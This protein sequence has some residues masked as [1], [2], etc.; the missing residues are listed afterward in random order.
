[1]M[2]VTPSDAVLAFRDK[3]RRTLRNG[4]IDKFK[5]IQAKISQKFKD[6]ELP[7]G[8]DDSNIR[9]ESD[10]VPTFNQFLLSVKKDMETYWYGIIR[11]ILHTCF[12]DMLS[13][14]D[15]YF[16]I[17]YPSLHLST[18]IRQNFDNVPTVC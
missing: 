10:N 11:I 7:E 1:M 5:E 3:M 18:H 6:P 8:V 15:Q 9:P 14:V 2:L 13:C 4:T 12:R 17:P 16:R